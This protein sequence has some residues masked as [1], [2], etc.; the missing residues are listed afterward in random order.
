MLKIL[1]EDRGLA[2]EMG[3]RGRIRVEEHYSLQFTVYSLQFTV[4]S[5]QFTVYS[6]QVTAPRIQKILAGLVRDFSE[7]FRYVR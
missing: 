3:L 6:L 4:Y 1:Y 7:K 2:N 5:L